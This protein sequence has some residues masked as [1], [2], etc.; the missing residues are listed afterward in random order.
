MK[1]SSPGCSAAIARCASGSTSSKRPCRAEHSVAALA[2]QATAWSSADGDA[3]TSRAMSTAFATVARVHREGG[4]QRVESGPRAGVRDP[5]A[6]G[7]QESR[8]PLR[9]AEHPELI[10]RPRQRPGH[11]LRFGAAAAGST[12]AS[13]ASASRPRPCQARACASASRAARSPERSSAARASRSPRARSPSRSACCG[14]GDDLGYRLR[15]VAV[16]R[17]G[18]QPQPV[19]EVVRTDAATADRPTRCGVVA[20]R[21]RRARHALVRRIAGGRCRPPDVAALRPRI[22]GLRRAPVLAPPPPRRRRRGRSDRR[23]TAARRRRDSP[24]PPAPPQAIRR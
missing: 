19:A 3:S 5:V 15:G 18:R 2:A 22:R 4:A 17:Q 21:R 12:A 16:H 9:L 20:R 7:L 1:R 11:Q 10:G 6:D 14:R 24:A 13:S 8:R 23:A